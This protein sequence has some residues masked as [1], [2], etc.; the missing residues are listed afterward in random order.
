MLVVGETRFPSSSDR[1][2]SH[3]LTIDLRAAFDFP[4][5]W[6]LEA[7]LSVPGPSNDAQ[8]HRTTTPAATF[9]I[10]GALGTT[11]HMLLD[12]VGDII[13]TFDQQS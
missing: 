4:H 12:S 9:V 11:C 5:S 3:V 7:D 6:L 13:S 1:P 8:K 10:A 2:Q